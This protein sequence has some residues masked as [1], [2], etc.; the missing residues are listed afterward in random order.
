MFFLIV[1]F[2]VIY[3]KTAVYYAVNV[4][5]WSVLLSM[6]LNIFPLIIAHNKNGYILTYLSNPSP[7]DIR[8]VSTFMV[9]NSTMMDI[10]TANIELL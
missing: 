5:C 4:L 6:S 3:F 2:K 10:F 1:F 8:S 7:L 9:I